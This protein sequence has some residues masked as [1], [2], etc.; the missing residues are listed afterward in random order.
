MSCH[1]R[2]DNDAAISRWSNIL[3]HSSRESLRK[4]ERATYV[5][6]EIDVE[7]LRGDFQDILNWTRCDAGVV[8]Q[9]VDV[10]IVTPSLLNES[11]VSVNICDIALEEVDIC[12]G[13][14]KFPDSALRGCVVVNV[15]NEQIKAFER[16]LKGRR[17]ANALASA[18]DK[19]YRFSQLR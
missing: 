11:W 5:H 8:H 9:T 16:K 6:I 13:G 17:T 3:N 12:T 18:R 2:N 15:C 19:G 10:A 1:R 4:K 7:V 14:T